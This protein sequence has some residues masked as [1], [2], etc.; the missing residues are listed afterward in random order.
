MEKNT[1]NCFWTAKKT[2]IAFSICLKSGRQ[3]KKPETCDT[4]IEI[5]KVCW[6]ARSRGDCLKSGT[7]TLKTDS[8]TIICYLKYR[9]RIS[10]K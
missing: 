3:R 4:C 7:P 10:P 5:D 2:G 6:K 1:G 8:Q 9:V